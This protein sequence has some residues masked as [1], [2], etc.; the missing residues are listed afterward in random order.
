[1]LADFAPEWVEFLR[2][3]LQVPAFVEHGLWFALATIARDC[4]SDSVATAVCLQAAMKQRSA[5]ALVLYAMDL[6]RHHGEFST[7]A[8]RDRFLHEPHWQPTR[9]YLERLAATPDWGEVVVAINLCFEPRVG[10][11]L[12][13]ELGIRAA[14]ASARHRHAGARPRRRP[15][16][17][18]GAGV[19]RGARP[20]AGRGP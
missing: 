2:Q 6:E 18:V 1:M 20:D 16:V 3:N 13:R 8:A 19:D 12:R 9:R 10:T 14:A 17:G 15:G 4:L 11:L 5:Q 7:E